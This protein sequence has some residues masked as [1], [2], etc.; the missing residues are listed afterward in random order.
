MAKILPIG[1]I[2]KK[3]N[4]KLMIIGHNADKKTNEYSY[5]VV[6]Y[7]IGYV[8]KEKTFT[9]KVSDE[10]EVLHTGYNTDRGEKYITNLGKLADLT[11]AQLVVYNTIATEALKRV[12][13][14]KQ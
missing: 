4:A 10:V 14:G 9:V 1:S 12:K 7:P 5:V 11:P 3:E 6:P 8:G 13:G 2:I